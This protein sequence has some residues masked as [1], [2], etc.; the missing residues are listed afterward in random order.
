[1]L[2]PIRCSRS[3]IYMSYPVPFVNLEKTIHINFRDKELLARALTHR[4]A[5]RESKTHGGHNERLEFL[6]D[7]VLE[8]VATEHLFQFK[9]K[10]EGELTNWRAALV[11]GEHLAKVAESIKLGDYL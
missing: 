3:V 4:S 11:R 9:L 6:G 8:L 2:L 5:V 1:M 10:T 7:A